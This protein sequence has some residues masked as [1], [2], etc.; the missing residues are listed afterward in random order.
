MRPTPSISDAASPERLEYE[1]QLVQS[2]RLAAIGELAAGVAHEINNPLFAILG[3]TEFLL[4]ETEPGTLA[5]KRLELIQQSGV[6]IKE[7]QSTEGFDALVGANRGCY[8]AFAAIYECEVPVIAAVHGFCLGGG[9]GLTGNA[10]IIIAS[11]DATSGSVIAKAERI[12][13]SS[14]GTSHCFL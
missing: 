3:L 4:K 10:D 12:V 14:S 2:G 9:I 5:H 13:P 7:M 6:E 1:R 8:A 11:D